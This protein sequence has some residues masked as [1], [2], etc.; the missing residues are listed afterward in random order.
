MPADLPQNAPDAYR[1]LFNEYETD[2]RP[3]RAVG[4]D[5][6]SHLKTRISS[7]EDTA[8]IRLPPDAALFL[9][10]NLDQMI[11]RPYYGRFDIQARLPTGI[12]KVESDPLAAADRVLEIILSN[13]DWHGEP[14][15]AHAV[16]QAI[17]RGWKPL[18]EM[19]GWA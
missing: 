5:T 9:L 12:F 18:S 13:I 19:F 2:W 15:S 11:L 14:I 6:V 16:M 17:D 8:K 10:V 1:F 3:I 7:W 4:R